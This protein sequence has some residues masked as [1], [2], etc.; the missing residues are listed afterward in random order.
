MSYPTLRFTEEMKGYATFTGDS[1]PRALMFHLD[2]TVPD[3]TRFLRE[4]GHA[5]Q[6]AGVVRCERLGGACP[7]ITGSVE[8]LRDGRSAC[9]VV[10]YHLLFVTP[11]GEAFTLSG[12]KQVR[13]DPG[14]DLWSDTSTLLTTITRG[15]LPVPALGEAEVAATGVL[16]IYLRDFLEQLGSFSVNAPT[17]MDRGALPTRA[18]PWPGGDGGSSRRPASPGSTA[19]A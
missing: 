19:P 1:A 8:L 2:I 16:Y 9:K 13:D 7:V 3:V 15:H 6:A 11:A 12:V 18:T 17:L 14:C 10:R 5:A 4:P